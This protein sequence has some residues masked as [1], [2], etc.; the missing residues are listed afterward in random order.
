MLS[1]FRHRAIHAFRGA[2]ATDRSDRKVH[3]LALAQAW[4]DEHEERAREAEA[5]NASLLTRR[6]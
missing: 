6:P 4:F 5:S 2:Q 1:N 3:L